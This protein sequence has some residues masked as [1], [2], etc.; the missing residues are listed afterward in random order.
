MVFENSNVSL[1]V[2]R[3][4]PNRNLAS[5]IYLSH[6]ISSL[7]ASVERP[8]HTSAKAQVPCHIL[9]QHDIESGNLPNN[10]ITTQPHPPAT[11]IIMHVI[12]ALAAH[13][14]VD[15][16]RKPRLRHQS[17]VGQGYHRQGRPARQAANFGRWPNVYTQTECGFE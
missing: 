8:N 4:N 17:R 11:R 13:L 16:D 15:E 3:G 5:K 6:T 10:Q 1:Q 2:G 14:G 12:D 9:Y 7:P